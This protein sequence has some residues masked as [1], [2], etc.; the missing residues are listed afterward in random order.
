MLSIL[1]TPMPMELVLEGM[2]KENPPYRELEAGNV[3][4]L[5]EPLGLDNCRVVRLISTNPMDYLRSEFQPGT[6]MKF[7]PQIKGTWQ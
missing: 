6:E 4:L 5:V 1:Y 7:V 2:F 3:K